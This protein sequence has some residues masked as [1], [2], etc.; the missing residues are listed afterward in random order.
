MPENDTV[1]DSF[2]LLIVIIIEGLSLLQSIPPTTFN[3]SEI[4]DFQTFPVWE[5]LE[6]GPI[7]SNL[8]FLPLALVFGNSASA[9]APL[10]SCAWNTVSN[11]CKLQCAADRLIPATPPN[12]PKTTSKP[13]NCKLPVTLSPGSQAPRQAFCTACPLLFCCPHFPS[14]FPAFVWDPPCAVSAF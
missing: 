5:L 14:H 1:P 3:H 8:V 4:S 7:W 9:S 10:S 11:Q 2:K 6:V 12:L 13:P